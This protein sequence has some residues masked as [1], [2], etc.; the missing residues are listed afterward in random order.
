MRSLSRL[1][2]DGAERNQAAAGW[3]S[4]NAYADLVLTL[5][6]NFVLTLTLN[7]TQ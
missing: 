1:G 5:T 7:S 3:E 6:L 2:N 4:W